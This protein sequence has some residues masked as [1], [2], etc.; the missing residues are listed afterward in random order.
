MGE[1]T[2]V[3]VSE[4]NAAVEDAL[5]PVRCVL[6]PDAD[7]GPDAER[8]TDARR[9]RLYESACSGS[10]TGHLSGKRSIPLNR[11][12]GRAMTK[13]LAD[14][15]ELR[16]VGLIL[17][18]CAPATPRATAQRAWGMVWE[19]RPRLVAHPRADRDARKRRPAAGHRS[20][21]PVRLRT[22]AGIPSTS[23]RELPQPAVVL[24]VLRVWRGGRKAWGT[25]PEGRERGP[26]SGRV[27]DLERISYWRFAGS[28]GDDPVC[29]SSR[30]EDST[31]VFKSTSDATTISEGA[32]D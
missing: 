18:A 29:T 14:R 4:S 16:Y 22:P 9:R 5:L 11:V 20:S 2:F 8:S 24:R 17:L 28:S 15:P 27:H 30:I 12:R 19:T 10:R 25:V 7:L 31:A 1:G 21:P 23:R 6:R 32:V 3:P 13:T 26:G